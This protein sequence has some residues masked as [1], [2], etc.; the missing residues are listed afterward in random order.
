M[1]GNAWA[2]SF[3]AHSIAAVNC[4]PLGD[5]THAVQSLV[6]R[7]LTRSACPVHLYFKKLTQFPFRLL[8]LLCDPGPPAIA[9]SIE[10]SC[11][12]LHDGYT[13]DFLKRFAG[14]MTCEEAMLELPLS[15]FISRTNAAPMECRH[16]HI[17]R[18]VS[19]L[20][21]QT[22]RPSVAMIS[23]CFLLRK[24]AIKGRL[25]KSPSGFHHETAKRV[26]R[27]TTK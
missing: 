26:Q 4:F 17:R 7:L 10:A 8:L 1:S 18:L 20:S 5:M 2:A 11:P 27:K 13:K 14:R 9:R 25:L 3:G 21:V 23:A 24:V 16:A 15:V 6:C 22:R 12:Q 19:S